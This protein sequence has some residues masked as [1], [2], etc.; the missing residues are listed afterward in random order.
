MKDENKPLLRMRFN[1]Y[2]KQVREHIE[3]QYPN[4]LNE[5]KSK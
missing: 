4:L 2:S 3:K 1:K 5:L